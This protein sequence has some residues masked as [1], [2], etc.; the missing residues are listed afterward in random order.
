MT[1]DLFGYGRMIADIGRTAGYADALKRHVTPESVVVDVGTGT[2]VFAL[3]A[4]RLGAR[5]VYAIEADDAIEW[6]R[7]IAAAN[8][9]DQQVTFIHEVSTRID[10]PE[11]ADVIVSDIHGAL[12]AHRQ[13]LLSIMDARDR[14]LAPGGSLIPRRE[15]LWAAI[16]EAATLHEKI[17]GVWDRDVFGIDMTVVR[18][19]VVNTC[20]GT[21]LCEADLVT[22]PE[23][24]TTIDY[25]SLSSAHLSGRAAWTIDEPRSAH[26]IGVWFDWDG[27]EGVAF[28][29]SPLVLEHHV[30]RQAFF[31]WPER[32]NLQPG[33]QVRVRLRADPVG[34]DYVYRWDTTVRGQDGAPKANF[35]QS[36]FLGQ[37]LSADRL[38]KQSSTFT[39]TLSEDGRIERTILNGAASGLALE[40]IARA[41]SA[42]FPHRFPEWTDA[43]RRVA[44][45]SCKYCE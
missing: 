7:R 15:T 20:H 41:V 2:G 29:N 37:V 35:V 30:Y 40:Q 6:G 16:V 24:W 1:N 26:G 3:L 45:V 33:D 32:V 38:R 13:S 39:P 8:G 4:A 43:H 31:P 28:S 11:K 18:P 9:L 27:A 44:E 34:S 12:P 36:D 22:R 25:A 17:I 23:C 19:M 42:A 21:R 10:L 14:F 5:K